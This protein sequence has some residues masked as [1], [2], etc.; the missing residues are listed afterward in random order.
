MIGHGGSDGLPGL[1]PRTDELLED[2]LDV[3]TEVRLRHP[4]Q[5]VFLCGTSMGGAIAV[6]V[7]HCADEPVDGVVLLS[8]LIKPRPS[9]LPHPAA[10][11]AL[12]ALSWV[13]PA[14]AV[15]PLPFR[16]PE[17]DRKTYGPYEGRMR[18]RSAATLL[19]VTERVQER[20]QDFSCPFFIGVGSRDEVID[21][22]GPKEFYERACT[23]VQDKVFKRYS[24]A[25]HVMLNDEEFREDIIAD[26]CAWISP[27][28]HR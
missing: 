3:L 6:H 24:G 16:Q 11:V 27:R 5:R 23:D 4:G 20:V 25:C 21:K 8:P 28:L 9:D 17:D 2:G 18:L 10:V 15:G 22:S 13:A 12:R 1:L 14:L 19:G 26:V 7:A